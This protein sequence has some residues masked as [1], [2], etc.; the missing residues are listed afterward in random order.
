LSNA[1]GALVSSTASVVGFVLLAWWASTGLIL[2]L[3]GRPLLVQR[4]AMLLATALLGLA[5]L[6]LAWSRTEGHSAAAHLSFSCTLVVWAWAEMAFLFGL[7]TGPRRSHCA[8][9]LT[10]RRRFSWAFQAL[11]YHELALCTLGAAVLAATWAGSQPTGWWT[12]AVLYFMRVSCKLNLFLGVRNRYESF[13]PVGLAYM[14][15]YFGPP[16]N[17]PLLGWCIAL[18]LLASA[19]AWAQVPAADHPVPQV[20][21]ASLVTLGLVE[22]LLLALPW[23]GERL[24]AWGL[25]SRQL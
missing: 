14:S 11:A 25:R 17:N 3:T 15:S 10:L 24:W 23:R 2:W 5:L 18:A 19:W 7:V 1:A 13:L 6:G 22:H 4:R 21:L 16:R 9:G 12:F 20:F 8:P